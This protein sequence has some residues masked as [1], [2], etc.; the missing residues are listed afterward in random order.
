MASYRILALSDLHLDEKTMHTFGNFIKFPD[1][2]AAVVAGDTSDSWRETYHWEANKILPKVRQLLHV[3]GNHE[4]F[5]GSLNGSPVRMQELTDDL[6]IIRGDNTVYEDPDYKVRFLMTTLWT[7]FAINSVNSRTDEDAQDYARKNAFHE[8]RE[9]MPE[10][11]YVDLDDVR[12]GVMSR[13]MGPKDAYERHKVSRAFLEAELAKP[14]DGRTVV[15]SHHAPHRKSIAPAF[16]GSKLNPAFASDLSEMIRKYQPDA[17]IH[18]HVHNA[19][20]YM[21]GNTR[22]VCNP[23]GYHNKNYDWKKVVEIDAPLRSG[24]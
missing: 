17:W 11:H 3:D 8:L 14:Y 1:V 23:R 7:D 19:S 24:G 21:V 4:F 5:G 16:V 18:G 6:G 10:Y 15:V 13:R 9:A 20:D 2:Q 22:I 12:N